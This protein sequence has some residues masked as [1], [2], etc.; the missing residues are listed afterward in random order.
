M[1]LQQRISHGSSNLG[2]ELSLE[3]ILQLTGANQSDERFGPELT[4]LEVMDIL[5]E[6]R[7]LPVRH[8]CL[9]CRQVYDTFSGFNIHR[10]WCEWT[11][12]DRL[13]LM[14]QHHIVGRFI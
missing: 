2:E 11:V 1:H 13:F 14:E 12:D 7:G 4:L 5:E 6:V 8:I 10:R 9:K 3:E